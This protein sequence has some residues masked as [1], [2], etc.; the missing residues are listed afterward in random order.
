MVHVGDERDGTEGLGHCGRLEYWVSGV[1]ERATV[2]VAVFLPGEAPA[3]MV[4]ARNGTAFDA[5]LGVLRPEERVE[6]VIG[7]FERSGLF[8]APMSTLLQRS[9]PT[10]WLVFGSAV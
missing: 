8:E 10:S 5:G 9:A 6:I 1:L 2:V 7:S 3:G 4:G